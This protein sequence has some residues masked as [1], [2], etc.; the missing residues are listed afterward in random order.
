MSVPAGPAGDRAPTPNRAH[1]W[2]AVPLAVLGFIPMVV[3]L[4]ASVMPATIVA[5]K[6]D[7]VEVDANHV[8]IRRGPD[9]AIRYAVVPADA[10]P[11]G[12]RLQVS[13]VEQFDDSNHILF[14]TVREPELPLFEYW[15][16]KDNAGTSFFESQ[17][18]RFGTV[19]AEE[20]QQIALSDMRNAKNDAYYVALSKLGYPVTIDWG[21]ATIQQIS[22]F[23]VDDTGKCN[24]R[25]SAAD[26][27]KA[28]DTITSVDGEPVKTLPDLSPLI[29]KHQVGDTVTIGFQRD[30]KDM[31]GDVTLLAAP[32][33]SGRVLIGVQMQDTRVVTI[34]NDIKVDFETNDIGG[35]SAGL[36]FTLTLIDR[37]SEGDLTGGKKVAVTG[38]IDVDGNVGAIGGLQSKAS[39]VRQAGAQYFIVPF[40]QGEADIAAA[41]KAA[42]PG[43]TIIPVKTIDEALAALEK[44]GG[45]KFVAPAQDSGSGGTADPTPDSVPTSAPTSVP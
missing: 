6:R 36:A 28:G 39:A 34:P 3:V 22:C 13:G 24:K 8:C 45:D 29:D 9:E 41:Q 2:W 16:A 27:L 25:S 23:G 10:S 15:L 21:P 4:V 19:S 12:S 43:V 20:D 7:C 33:G 5:S 26:V 37:L 32:D 31:T 1:R 18:D 14:V 30:G 11:A 17:Q 40:N 38:T 44:I 35:P 42:G